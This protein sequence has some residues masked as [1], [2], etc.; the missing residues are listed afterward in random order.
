MSR[1]ENG[2][3]KFRSEPVRK[4]EIDIEAAEIAAF[5][6]IDLVYLGVG[7]NLPPGR[8]F[9]MRE[10]H[11]SCGE[12]TALPDLTGTHC[13]QALPSHAWRQ[14]HADTALH[15]LPPPRHH[16]I[17]D[18]M[19]R[20]VIAMPEHR[21]LALHDWRLLRLVI[22]LYRIQRQR[23]ERTVGG[24]GRQRIGRCGKQAKSADSKRQG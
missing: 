23:W 2:R 13:R 5:L 19:V 9:D 22:G 15:R 4:I 12:Q 3:R 6:V 21:L 8:L 14:L 1:E 10:G 17:W 24:I 18:R 20:K 7:E 16:G 11:Q